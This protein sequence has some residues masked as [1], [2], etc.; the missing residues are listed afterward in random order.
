[1]C[2]R[3]YLRK[4]PFYIFHEMVYKLETDEHG[5]ILL[6]SKSVVAT[7]LV[8]VDLFHSRKNNVVLNRFILMK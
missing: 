2:A 3:I 5:H 6:L 1:M 4:V 8:L 7:L